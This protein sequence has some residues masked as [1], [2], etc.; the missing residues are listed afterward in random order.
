M[1]EKIQTDTFE[2]TNPHDDGGQSKWSGQE[3]QDSDGWM[4]NY[5]GE[6]PGKGEAWQS[7]SSQT[8]NDEKK[9]QAPDAEDAP[10]RV[11]GEKEAR[12]CDPRFM[13][14]IDHGSTPQLLLLLCSHRKRQ[15]SRFARCAKIQARMSYLRGD[16]LVF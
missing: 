5:A 12:R 7:T 8:G 14:K 1:S 15:K 2:I 16:E 4:T 3:R 9:S 11:Q 13:R 6:T 10:I